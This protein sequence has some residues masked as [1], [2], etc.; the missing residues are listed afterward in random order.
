MSHPGAVTPS[1]GKTLKLQVA[2]KGIWDG[3]REDWPPW[4][5]NP[6]PA[7][8]LQGPHVSRHLSSLSLYF[9]LNQGYR[10]IMSSYF[11][12]KLQR[13]KGNQA[14]QIMCKDPEL[15]FEE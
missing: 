7:I 4:R 15:L 1:A 3:D 9:N 6:R 2:Q 14:V 8:A 10:G 12:S 11:L 13:S 5:P